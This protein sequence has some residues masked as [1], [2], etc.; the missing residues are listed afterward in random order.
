VGLDLQLSCA[1]QDQ[2][3]HYMI[4]IPDDQAHVA[5]DLHECASKPFDVRLDS[6]ASVALPQKV[7]HL[8]VGKF[9][10]HDIAK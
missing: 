5:V 1:D 7:T 4:A 2:S 3:A 8:S 6:D 10:A 9:S